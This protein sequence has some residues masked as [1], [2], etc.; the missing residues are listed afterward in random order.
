TEAVAMCVFKEGDANTVLVANQLKDFFGFERQFSMWEAIGRRRKEKQ[1]MYVP[2]PPKE[3]ELPPT[4]K[5]RLPDYPKL[6]LVSD[7]SR[8]IVASIREVR[9]S[10]VVGGLLALVILFFFLRDVKS[11]AI[12]GISIP[13]STMP[14]CVP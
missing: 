10:A 11:T 1:G 9:E 2:P 3:G 7:Q 6:T 13:T 4:L 8:F 14:P 5:S 12:I